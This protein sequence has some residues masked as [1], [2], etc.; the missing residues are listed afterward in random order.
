M[1]EIALRSANRVPAAPFRVEKGWMGALPERGDIA[2]RACVFV[3]ETGASAEPGRGTDGGTMSI[4]AG[5]SR[6][7]PISLPVIFS[8]G[9]AGFTT[10]GKRLPDS[11][12]GM[13][14]RLEWSWRQAGM[15][16][17]FSG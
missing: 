6:R 1:G 16:C 4:R 12:G 10:P 3:G 11:V 14:P 9:G 13:N 7:P 17:R 5:R 8:A 2:A 15:R